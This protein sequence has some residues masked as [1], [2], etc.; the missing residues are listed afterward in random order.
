MLLARD[1]P[2]ETGGRDAAD[3]QLPAA[4]VRGHPGQA[5]ED[6]GC[7]IRRAGAALCGGDPTIPAG[8]PHHQSEEQRGG[9]GIHVSERPA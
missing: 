5:R 4:P 6:S 9:E 8:C 3:P 1:R 7:A 2:G